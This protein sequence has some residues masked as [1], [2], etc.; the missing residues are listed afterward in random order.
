[1][2]K[3]LF[4]WASIWIAA[5]LLVA[6]AAPALAPTSPRIPV[7]PAL[8]QA[9]EGALLGTDALGRDFLSR[10]IYG[11]RYSMLSSFAATLITLGIGL[12]LSLI[13]STRGGIVDR[14]LL[15]LANAGLAIPGLLLAMLFVAGLGPGLPTVILAVGLGGSPGFI[16]LSRTIFK[17]IMHEGY[18]DAA[19]ALGA[20][21]I[22][23]ALVHLLPNSLSQILALG[24]THYAWAFLGTTTLTFLGLAGDPALP[25]WGAMLDAG[26]T[27]LVQAPLLSL[28]PGLLIALTVLAVHRL[29]AL[30]SPPENAS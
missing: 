1:M 2:R 26:R 10:L 17:S 28:L 14:L 8:H 7:G 15:G 21:R 19:Q 9:G 4:G 3:R 22:R 24:T 6:V 30:L 11:A 16:R 27:Y 29:G 5:V 13:A 18:V 12:T 20:S 23:I 25:E